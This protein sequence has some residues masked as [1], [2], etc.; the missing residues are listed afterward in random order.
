LS[1]GRKPA[2]RSKSYPVRVT[3]S[4]ES[5]RVPFTGDVEIRKAF[6]NNRSASGI[7]G[8]TV[9]VSGSG[10]YDIGEKSL[11]LDAVELTHKS[12]TAQLL[13]EVDFADNRLNISGKLTQSIAALPGGFSGSASGFVQA[14]GAI[15][16]FELGLNLNLAGVT[17]SVSTS[18]RSS[19]AAALSAAC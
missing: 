19:K 3:V 2:C 17:A 8:D 13:G 16:D 14:K 4:L 15:R 1:S 11:L 5:G 18:T 10:N 7:V 6:A 12:G 9:K